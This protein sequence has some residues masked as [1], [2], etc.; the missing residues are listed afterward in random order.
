MTEA[1]KNGSDLSSSKTP[2]GR[3]GLRNDL[4]GACSGF[5]PVT[6]CTLAPPHTA[7]RGHA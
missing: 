1:A 7:A 6:A 2:M 4:F 3:V 5:T